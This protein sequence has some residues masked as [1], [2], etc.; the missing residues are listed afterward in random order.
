MT[1]IKRPTLARAERARDAAICFTHLKTPVGQLLLVGERENEE[2]A[3]LGLYFRDEPHASRAIPEGARRDDR[4]FADARAQ[5]E[6][7]FA[8]SRRAFDLPLAPRGT[9]FQR[10]VWR[11]LAAIPYGTTCTY[12]AIARSIGSPKAVRAVGAANGKN[13]LSIIVP[14]HRVV[15]QN[16]T[17]TG[18]AGGLS[19]KQRLLALESEA[20]SLRL[21]S[22]G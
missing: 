9:A 22:P 6:A 10:R 5:L 7:Y 21:A 11:A 15:G 2:L 13:P 18:Y 19:R 4:A 17:L 8:G 20:A 3:L 14:C 16:G 1:T 12:G